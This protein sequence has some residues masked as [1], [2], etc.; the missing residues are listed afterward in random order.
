MR[1]CMGWS[2]RVSEGMGVFFIYGRLG[3]GNGLY[4]ERER[5]N[6]GIIFVF[7]SESLQL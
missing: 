4:R 6:C 1:F 7:V 5:A 2:E 3:Y